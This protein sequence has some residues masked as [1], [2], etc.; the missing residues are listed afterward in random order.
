MLGQATSTAERRVGRAVVEHAAGAVAGLL[1][2]L[3]QR[4][5]RA[6]PLF[7]RSGEQPG[8]AEQAGDVHVVSAGVH[9]RHLGAVR[10]G[11]DA[12]LAYGRPVCLLDRQGVHV[13]P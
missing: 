5:H 4:D 13:G 7:G 2:R 12:V 9:D 11:R 1:G 6:A 8:R 10:V 3:E